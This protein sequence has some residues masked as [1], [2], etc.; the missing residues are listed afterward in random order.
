MIWAPRTSS[1]DGPGLRQNAPKSSQDASKTPQDNFKTPKIASKT[2]QNAFKL[3]QDAKMEPQSD[4]KSVLD[5]NMIRKI[6]GFPQENNYF[7]LLASFKIRF[8][9]GTIL[10]PT[11]CH[12]GHRL[13]RFC[14][15]KCPAVRKTPPNVPRRRKD[16][17]QTA[18]TRTDQSGRDQVPTPK[19]HGKP[20]P[21][22]YAFTGSRIIDLRSLDLPEMTPRVT[23]TG[24]LTGSG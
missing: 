20:R 16:V 24:S 15:P 12:C 11:S 9:S 23:H 21:A 7:Q 6:I 13:R 14:D 10:V 2:F 8:A 4:F 22:R 5:S 17:P 1:R 19:P 3:P 18:K